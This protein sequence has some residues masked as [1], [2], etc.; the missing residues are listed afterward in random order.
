LKRR[1]KQMR[2]QNNTVPVATGRV[3]KHTESYARRVVKTMTSEKT[4]PETRRKLREALVSLFACTD[5]DRRRS[6]S[7]VENV[8]A[9]LGCT[10]L[11]RLDKRYT[12]AREARTRLCGVMEAYDRQARPWLYPWLNISKRPRARYARRIARVITPSAPPALQATA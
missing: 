9:V 10:G 3:H 11:Y 4:P 5:I 6:A 2:T 7:K 8:S 1:F 12:E